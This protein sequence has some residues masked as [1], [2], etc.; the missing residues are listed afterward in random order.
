MPD[1]E[2][3]QLPFVDESQY[4]VVSGDGRLRE[5]VEQTQNLATPR[6][7]AEREFA[8][9]PG[10]P[11]HEALSKNLAQFWVSGTEVVDPDR[12]VDVSTRITQA[13]SAAAGPASRL[14][15]CPP[16][17]QVVGHFHARSAPAELG[18]RARSSQWSRSDAA[19]RRGDRRRG[20]E[21]FSWWAPGT[22]NDI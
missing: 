7:M 4:L 18:E 22:S 6:E 20:R 3:E 14:T 15:H 12:R 11:Q 5:V 2:P 13:G 10:V 17:A 16:V 8:S 21:L 9:H 19:L 1:A